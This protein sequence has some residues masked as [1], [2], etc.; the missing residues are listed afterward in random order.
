TAN[1]IVEDSTG[2]W[3]CTG[4]IVTMDEEGYVTLRD[5]A[6]EMIK[7]RAYQVAPAELESVLLEHPDITDAAV[8]PRLVGG[9]DGEIP[10]AF[11]VRAEGAELAADEV[12]A[13]VSERVAPYKKVREVEF[14]DSV[15]KSPTGKILRRELKESAS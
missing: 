10:K 9:A 14:I 6:K 11:V 2:R 15:P 12:M 8:V 13:H 3:L 5:R 4:D 1:T 7:Y